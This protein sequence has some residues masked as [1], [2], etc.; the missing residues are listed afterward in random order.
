M[1]AWL[2]DKDAAVDLLSSLVRKPGPGTHPYELKFSLD[3]WPLRGNP[4]F[5]ALLADPATYHP[6]Y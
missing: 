4:R 2:G 6:K 1:L 5:E 3:W